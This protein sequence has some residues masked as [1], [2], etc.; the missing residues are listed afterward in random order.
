MYIAPFALDFA[1]E[2][3]AERLSLLAARVVPPSHREGRCSRHGKRALSSE[4]STSPEERS[5]LAP[6]ADQIELS[7]LRLYRLNGSHAAAAEQYAH[8]AAT[9]ASTFG[10]EPPALEVLVRI[11]KVPY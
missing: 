1:Y 10:I 11:G 9:L 2:E 8:Y 6:E 7:L 3:W 5:D 4:E